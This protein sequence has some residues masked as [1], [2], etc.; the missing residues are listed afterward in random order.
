MDTYFATP[1]GVIKLR[2]AR[3][4]DAESFR[5]VRLEALRLEGYAFAADYAASAAKP[6]SQWSER[7]S[8]L[9]DS[10]T[11][12]LAE[13]YS[14]LLGMCGIERG[15]S[16]KLAH[17]AHIWG[18]YVKREWRGMHIAEALIGRCLDWA[19]EHSVTIVKL[20]VA[21]TNAP[22]I[23]S[24]LRAGFAVYGVEP[25]ALCAD[26]VTYDELLMARAV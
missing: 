2:P 13:Q 21:T 18:V 19:R 4:E 12:Y 17:S 9:D 5:E 25:Q 3:V 1:H 26:G 11:I 14:L 8:S 10:G 22:A 23:R 16:P 7:L 20:G 15:N 6:A 24:Y